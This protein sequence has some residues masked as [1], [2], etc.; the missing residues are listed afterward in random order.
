MNR[1]S[2]NRWLYLRTVVGVDVVVVDV[3]VVRVVGGARAVAG[4][5]VLEAAARV[6]ELLVQVHVALGA[7]VDLL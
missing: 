2:I 7:V 1:C 4:P 6:A 3:E 5:H